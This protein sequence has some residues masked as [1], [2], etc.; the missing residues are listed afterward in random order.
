MHSTGLPTLKEIQDSGR[1]FFWEDKDGTMHAVTGVQ[2]HPGLW[3][4]W[5]SQEGFTTKEKHDHPEI[6]CCIC[7]SAPKKAPTKFVDYEGTR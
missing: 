1:S 3:L 7:Q 2:I 6:T 4:L 5:T